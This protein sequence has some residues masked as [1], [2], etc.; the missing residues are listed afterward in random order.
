MKP[1]DKVLVIYVIIMC[2]LRYHSL[3]TFQTS[4]HCIL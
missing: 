2:N 4:E 1:N 3:I